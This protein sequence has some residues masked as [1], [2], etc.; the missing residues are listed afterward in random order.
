MLTVAYGKDIAK[1]TYDALAASDIRDYLKQGMSVTL[2]PNLVVARPA[3]E[4]AT[5]HPEVAEGVL[6]FL[7]EY[8]ITDIKIIESAWIGDS[9]KRAFKV[10]GYEDLS[11]KYGV[12]LVDLKT[13]SCTVMSHGGLGMEICDAA[14]GTDFL[15][16]MP[17]L[18][19]HC[20]TRLTCCIKNLKGCI[21]DHEKRRFH[22]IG[23]HR[24]IAVLGA[25]LKTG[26]NVV[27]SI[28]GDLSFE[29]G[30]NPVE[31]NRVIA[32]R[33]PLLID[34]YGAGLIGYHPDEIEHVRLA[35]GLG[36]GEYFSAGIKINE[37]NPGEKPLRKAAGGRAADM[38]KGCVTEEAACSACYSA[39]MYALH[40][41][42]TPRPNVKISIGQGFAGKSSGDGLGVGDCTCGF[43][44]HVPGCPPSA[45]DILE[46]F[47]R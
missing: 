35:K 43:A 41:A 24:P 36:V 23:L 28:C 40:R 47:R 7:K 5:T 3:N 29:E 26:Y 2:K 34:S 16:N 13:D 12:P 22:S 44:R 9:T 31:A 39:L 37:I 14:L 4:G 20:Q 21:P 46:A 25:L 18:K 8:G 42:G 1:I 10:C 19:A 11:R 33:D 38:Y 15:I 30:G 32:G 6:R 17:V 27:D 45:A